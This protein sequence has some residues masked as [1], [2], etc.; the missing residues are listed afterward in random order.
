MSKKFEVVLSASPGDFLNKVQTSARSS[1]VELKG[2]ESCG[3]FSGKGIE[4]A[5][6]I[7][8][9]VLA[10]RIVKKPLLMPWALIELAV[11]DYFV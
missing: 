5:Y 3:R 8:G 1:G 9:N 2:D 4:G 11:R 10:I 7:Q 6:E